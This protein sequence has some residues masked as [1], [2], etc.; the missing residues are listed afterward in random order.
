[1]RLESYLDINVSVGLLYFPKW[2]LFYGTGF[3]YD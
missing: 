2:A 3:K 1:M